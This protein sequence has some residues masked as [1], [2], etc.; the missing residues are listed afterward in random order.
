MEEEDAEAYGF[1]SFSELFDDRSQSAEVVSTSPL[2]AAAIKRFWMSETALKRFLE[3]APSSYEHVAAKFDGVTVDGG[4][5]S[6]YYAH[7]DA[8]SGIVWV[9][10][11][12]SDSNAQEKRRTELKRLRCGRLSM[13]CRCGTRL[14]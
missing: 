4:L 6:A 9:Q 8:F 11:Q 1:G 13:H 5:G 12:R 7:V 3:S 10:T 14:T 2:D